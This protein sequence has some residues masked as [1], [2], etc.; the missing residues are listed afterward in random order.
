MNQ[1]V[2]DGPRAIA[3]IAH[4]SVDEVVAK[5]GDYL[6]IGFPRINHSQTTDGAGVEQNVA[7]HDLL[8]GEDA[9]VERISVCPRYILAGARPA[10]LGDAVAAKRSRDQS[11]RAWGR[12]SNNVEAVQ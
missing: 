2:D 3:D 9:D 7:M 8:F 5:N 1:A 12:Y 10:A 11:R 6:V 4:L